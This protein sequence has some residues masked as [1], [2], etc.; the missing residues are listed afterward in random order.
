MTCLA[1]GAKWVGRDARGLRAPSAALTALGPGLPSFPVTDFDARGDFDPAS[2]RSRLEWLVPYGAGALF[3]A[4]GTGEFFS[5][6]PREYGDIVRC[7]YDR[8]VPK[9]AM[10]RTFSDCLFSPSAPADE[11]S[12]GDLAGCRVV[13]KKHSRE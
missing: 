10:D 2:Y 13:K 12:T 5:L 4:G 9:A 6:E 8:L 7:A 3:A 11:R 1:R